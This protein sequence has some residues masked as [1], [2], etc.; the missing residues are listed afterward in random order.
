M[1]F[2]IILIEWKRD[3]KGYKGTDN[4]WMNS[5][6]PFELV[7]YPPTNDPLIILQSS[8]FTGYKFKG[9]LN[10]KIP[11]VTHTLHVLVSWFDQLVKLN[12]YRIFQIWIFFIR[13]TVQKYRYL[14]TF[15]YLLYEAN[16][17]KNEWNRLLLPIITLMLYHKEEWS[18]GEWVLK[19]RV[20][21]RHWRKMKWE[22]SLW[23]GTAFPVH[24]LF[25]FCNIRI[26][27]YSSFFQTNS[28]SLFFPHES[29]WIV[30]RP[31]IVTR[32]DKLQGRAK[33]KVK[34]KMNRAMRSSG[35]GNK[36]S[37]REK[38]IFSWTNDDGQK[39]HSSSS[40]NTII[41]SEKSFVPIV[42]TFIIILNSTVVCQQFW[43]Y[44]RT[45]EI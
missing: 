6:I 24:I 2:T 32:N 37:K 43:I 25:Y 13:E 45:N 41:K 28:L 38:G 18:K 17:C 23:A 5:F 8:L 20:R 30:T 1:R 21:E 26:K 14:E 19:G 11:L 44:V 34:K 39:A 4:E 12:K 36:L 22:T 7:S 9:S 15:S 3:G 10:M 33:E 16:F 31:S 27:I 42:Y 29:L 35:I 40:S